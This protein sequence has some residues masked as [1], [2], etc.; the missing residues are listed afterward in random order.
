LEEEA[1]AL[2]FE[3]EA[4]LWEAACGGAGGVQGGGALR[5]A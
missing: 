1:L 3:E 4:A 5:A 2:R